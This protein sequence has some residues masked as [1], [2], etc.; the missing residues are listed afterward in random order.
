[1]SFT[2][3]GNIVGNATTTSGGGIRGR[4]LEE[5]N[6]TVYEI[7][8]IE[9]NPSV[10]PSTTISD[11]TSGIST[12]VAGL[13]SNQILFVSADRQ[14]GDFAILSLDTS[15]DKLD[16]MAK[17][18]GEDLVQIHQ[19]AGEATVTE[20]SA[21]VVP[22]REW[23]CGAEGVGAVV[24]GGGGRRIKEAKDDHDHNHHGH[25]HHEHEEDHEHSHTHNKQDLFEQF[26]TSDLLKDLLKKRRPA[27]E[28]YPTD[29]FPKAYTY[30]VD[31]YIEIDEGLITNNVDLTGA[32]A[33]VNAL[34]SAASE[35]YER[36]VDT[37]CKFSSC[38]CMVL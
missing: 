23:S 26:K 3:V 36:E 4:Y 35:I 10:K 33:Y 5:H 30:E 16:G 27:R 22:E 14:H 12:T 2:L 13:N 8:V 32:T 17:K 7:D 28:L 37:H 18:A 29:N 11:P 9:A 15:I 6:V 20:V 34:I 24:E 25:H 38:I 21:V 19:P 31:I 1:M